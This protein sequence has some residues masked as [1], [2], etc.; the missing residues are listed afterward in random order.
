MTGGNRCVRDLQMRQV[1]DRN[2]PTSVKTATNQN[3]GDRCE[4]ANG[5][6]DHCF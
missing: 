5:Y 2:Q 6:F 1:N 3:V 4:A